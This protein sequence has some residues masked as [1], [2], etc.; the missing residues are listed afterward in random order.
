M[1]V[2]I[3]SINYSIAIWFFLNALY[4]D[5]FDAAVELVDDDHGS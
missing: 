1:A 5:M 4:D 3:R 2:V